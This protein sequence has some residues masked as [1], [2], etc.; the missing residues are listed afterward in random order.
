[1]AGTSPFELSN[2]SIY[3]SWKEQKLKSYPRSAEELLVSVENAGEV[4]DEEYR[5]LVSRCLA[6]NLVI[7]QLKNQ[8]SGDTEEGRQA[9]RQMSNKLGLHRLES[10]RSA[11]GDGL[12]AIE[13]T[14]TDGKHG[15]IPYTSKKLNW[16][17]DGCYNKPAQRIKAFLMH[18]VRP[19]TKGGENIFFDHEV[20]YLRLRD[21]N[22]DFIKALTHRRAMTIPGFTDQDGSCRPECAGAVFSTDRYIGSLHMRFSARK[23]NILWK[24]DKLTEEAVAFLMDLLEN[25][26]LRFQFKLDAGHGIACNNVL[27]YR[28]AFE[29]TDA[30]D[31]TRLMLRGRYLDRVAENCPTATQLA[32]R[33]YDAGEWH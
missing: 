11:D 12:V 23:H 13:V 16:H 4:S 8:N 7:Y 28:Q 30:S 3:E 29:D 31:Q 32:H 2:S 19:A 10:H 18:C 21:E 20:A 15:F 33:Q 5:S 6:T 26:P 9:A 25:D 14:D 22:P 17:T 1:M 27:H 24:N